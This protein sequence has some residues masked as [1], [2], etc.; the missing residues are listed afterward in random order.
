MGSI[1]SREYET[2]LSDGNEKVGV[3]SKV[4]SKYLS[5]SFCGNKIEVNESSTITLFA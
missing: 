1:L 3:N 5:V 2:C 4:E